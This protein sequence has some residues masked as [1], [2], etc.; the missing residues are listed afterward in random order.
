MK[1]LYK[2]VWSDVPLDYPRLQDE[3]YILVKIFINL[4]QI[5]DAYF[6]R[7]KDIRLALNYVRE[8]GLVPTL[9]KIFSRSGEKRRND[10]FISV[11]FGYVNGEIPVYFVAPMHP[12]CIDM[13]P[14]P[15][16]LMCTIDKVD[17]AILPAF[18]NPA[19]QHLNLVDSKIRLSLELQQMG[20]WNA[21]SGTELPSLDWREIRKI[22]L[23][24]APQQPK[25]LPVSPR[26]TCTS[27]G[28]S[29][30]KA[31]GLTGTL[32][33]Y[34]NYAKSVILP[35]LPQ[36]LRITRIHDVDPLQI[37]AKIHRQYICSS[38][39]GIAED[40]KNTVFFIAG[41]HHTHSQLAEDALKR[42]AHVV[43]EK[44]LVTS[45]EQLVSLE[46][47]FNNSTGSYFACFHKRYMTFNRWIRQDLNI[48]EFDPINYHAVVYEVPLPERHWY[49]WPNSRSRI[50][51][52]G[53]HWLDHF[54]YINN[55]SAVDRSSAF[56][57]PDGTLNTSVVLKNG[58]FFSMILTDIG[59][60]RL[61]VQ[62]YVEL[63]QGESTVTIING[64]V[65]RAENH[66]RI[67]RHVRKSRMHSY[68]E[69]Y[70]AIGKN[71]LLQQT[72]DNW[73]SIAASSLLALEVDRVA[74]N[75]SK[76]VQN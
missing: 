30:C 70:R 72:G 73:T 36:Q 29:N 2:G 64:S 38:E 48:G 16:Y 35:N 62:D 46:P 40:D 54:L 71:L 6:Q 50:I 22:I 75:E 59:S 39:P 11:G 4:A 68:G 49:R 14:L 28:L 74:M 13:L 45:H 57:A 3:H 44:P 12:E 37:P 41:F 51:S 67:V 1:I 65:Y 20:G 34:G 61:G 7:P 32:L 76:M 15:A 18:D 56:Y 21:F 5:N 55:F 17:L 66:H 26:T 9:T 31:N 8:I 10:K 27:A 23:N 58:A 19:I 24:E 25:L 53:C 52:N 43:V 63:R 47:I 60:Q 33:G 69:M 42:N